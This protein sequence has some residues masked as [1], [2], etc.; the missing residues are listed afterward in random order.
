MGPDKRS[1]RGWATQKYPGHVPHEARGGKLVT[2][3]GADSCRRRALRGEGLPTSLYN[4]LGWGI[5]TRGYGVST[6]G[7]FLRLCWE[8]NHNGFSDLILIEGKKNLNKKVHAEKLYSKR[9]PR[10]KS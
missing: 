8:V 1:P 3:Y 6:G 7:V 9:F 5:T 10:D 2:T 4:A